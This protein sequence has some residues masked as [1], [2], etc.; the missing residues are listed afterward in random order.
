MQA[1][2]GRMVSL[3]AQPGLLAVVAA[4]APVEMS[5]ERAGAG[6]G[7]P[8]DKHGG[9]GVREEDGDQGIAELFHRATPGEW[10]FVLARGAGAPGSKEIE[11]DDAQP[12]DDLDGVLAGLAGLPVVLSE[13][14]V[15]RPVK[16]V[17]YAPVHA[18]QGELLVGAE[19]GSRDGREEVADLRRL[20]KPGA[21]EGHLPHAPELLHAR[22]VHL[23][24]VL[25][26]ER[27]QLA[28]DADT[29]APL[30]GVSAGPGGARE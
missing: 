24:S 26:R 29:A 27:V 17:L 30:G 22:E 20:R 14:G 15:E 2:G 1:V 25:H 4:G 6:R 28:V 23:R 13:H 16:P 5:E 11:A 9:R 8:S 3:V 19:E 10:L 21:V 12:G 18:H 7:S